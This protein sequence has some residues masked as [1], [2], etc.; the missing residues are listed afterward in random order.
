MGTIYV[1]MTTVTLSDDVEDIGSDHLRVDV[2]DA[3]TTHFDWMGIGLENLQV[4]IGEIVSPEQ[5]MDQLE[6]TATVAATERQAACSHEWAMGH[7]HCMKGCGLTWAAWRKAQDEQE[8]S[9]EAA[10][11]D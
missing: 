3:V 2:S 6:T 11:H 10:R 9:D 8:A 4:G 7:T 1:V 5:L